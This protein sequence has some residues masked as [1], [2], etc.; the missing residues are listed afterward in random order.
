LLVGQAFRRSWNYRGV[1]PAV[2]VATVVG[3][4][5]VLALGVRSPRQPA[6]VALCTP[7]MAV[8]G[9]LLVSAPDVLEQLLITGS[10]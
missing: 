10:L 9:V 8:L 5:V 1:D 7:L 6:L 4:V 3:I 2:A